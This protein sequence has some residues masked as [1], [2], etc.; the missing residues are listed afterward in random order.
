MLMGDFAEKE[1]KKKKVGERLGF[2]EFLVRLKSVN[3]IMYR[4]RG[5]DLGLVTLVTLICYVMSN[6]TAL[7]RIL[8]NTMQFQ[9]LYRALATA[10]TEV[11]KPNKKVKCISL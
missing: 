4:L 10:D 11:M 8:Y 1:I 9:N 5:F 2:R 7:K 3:D 6:R